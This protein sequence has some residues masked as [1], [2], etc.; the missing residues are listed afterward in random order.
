MPSKFIQIKKRDGRLVPFDV[1][2]ISRAVGLAMRASGE[3]DG[4]EDSRRVADAVIQQLDL[5]FPESRVPTV[6]EIQDLVEESLILFDFAK[7]AKSYILYRQERARIREK[8]RQVPGAVRRK[9]EENQKYFRNEL[10]EFIFYRTYSRW[11]EE[12][13]RRETWS[14]SI[15]RY[16]NFMKERLGNALSAHE[17]R[18][19]EEAILRQDV[20]PSMR[21]LWSAGP[22]VRASHASAYNCAYVAPMQIQDLVEIMYLL[23]CGVGVGFSV[24]S[25]CVQ[26]FP[27]IERQKGVKIKTHVVEDSKEGWCEALRLGLDSWYGG[28]DVEFDFSQVRPAG[29]RLHTM[30]GRSSGPEPLKALLKFSKKMILANQGR[31]LRSIDIYDLICKLGQGVM[32]GGVRRSALISLSD[33]DDREMREAKTGHFYLEHPDRSMTN[34]SVAYDQ[35]PDAAAFLEEWIA[36]A[37]SGSG[38]RG[39]FNRGSLPGQLP[40]RRWSEFQSHWPVCGTNPCGE[41]ILRSKQFCNLTEV[42]ARPQDS[43]KMLL[44]KVEIASILGTYQA[45]LTDFVFLSEEWKR[46]CDEERLLGVS[47]TGQWDSPETRNPDVLSSMAQKAIETNLLYSK[48]MGIRAAAAI[49][50]VKPSGTVSQLVDSSSG[51]HPRHAKYYVRRVRVSSLDPLCQMLRDE[52]VPHRPEV[53]QLEGQATTYVFEFPIQAPDEAVVQGNLSA[54]EQLEHWKKVKLSYTEHNPS[55][56]ISVGPSEWIRAADWVYENWERLGGLSFLPRDESVYP[57]AP[58]E[59]ISKEE[60]E[61]R[62]KAFPRLDF[63][64]L[65]LYERE[66][67]TSGAKVLACVG[68][69]C[70][71]DLEE[72]MQALSP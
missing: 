39:V 51:M 42:V 15:E 66:D 29:A 30:G 12:E 49:T 9:V 60:Y 65:V 46:N 16:M 5:R 31:R 1:T 13:R 7:T 32:M 34:N 58:F 2:R 68:G 41:I 54:M 40:S 45:T 72:G 59:A 52:K 37:K 62:V 71:I 55:V 69:S 44:E 56:T 26:R 48:R 53:G 36:L 19:I 22:A 10:A 25:Q 17:Y 6:E 28:L 11:I 20:M 50:C 43:K 27:I 24:E 4:G 64:R 18:R 63:S 38:E 70:E 21:L 3:G 14:E 61:E 8:S 67:Q 33:L 47:I 23:M 57:L 35:K